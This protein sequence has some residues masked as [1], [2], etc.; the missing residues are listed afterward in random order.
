MESIN[1]NFK[2]KLFSNSDISHFTISRN[3]ETK[4]GEN[5]CDLSTAK[6]IIIGVQESLGPLANK[7]RKGAENAFEPFLSKFLNMQANETLFGQDV[8]VLG[9]IVSIVDYDVTQDLGELVKDLDKFLVFILDNYVQTNQIPIVIGGGHNNAYPLI[10]FSSKRLKGKI[11]VVNLD[12]HADYRPLEG[13]HSGNPFSYAFNEGYVEKYTVFGI[14]QRYNNQKI[15]SNLKSD[16]HTFTYFEDYLDDKLNWIND[17]N[18]FILKSNNENKLFTGIELDLDAIEYM[19]SSAFSPVGVS[20]LLA[21]KYIR[22]MAKLNKIAYIHLPEG[23][24]TNTNEESVVGKT[25]AYLVS[26]FISCHG[27]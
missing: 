21:R 1:K 16:G 17:F 18:D 4:I 19:P 14:H 10:K 9:S 6:Y 8:A 11:N 26:D 22:K 27:A 3:G 24:P 7:G 25:L 13:R 23:A 12:A 20:N 5:L 2:F 15:I